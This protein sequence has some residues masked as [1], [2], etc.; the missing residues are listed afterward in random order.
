[1]AKINGVVKDQKGKILEN[2][3]VLFVDRASNVLASG[4]SNKD[5]EY[6]LQISE[7]TNGMVVG[8]YS[9]GEEYLAFAFDNVSTHLPHHIEIIVGDVEFVQFRRIITRDR[10]KYTCSF[11]LAS[12][13]RM[14]R[15]E[16]HL[17]PEGAEASLQFRMD[18]E[19]M[20]AYQLTKEIVSV[21]GRGNTIDFWTLSFAFELK[22]RGKVLELIYKDK[23]SYGILKSY[24]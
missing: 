1:M 13:S 12:L 10:E 15:G 24:V 8:T 9:Y 22:D 19:T 2:A 7:K 4:Y 23:D 6:Y 16:I 18:G 3:E 17:S 11:Q 20:K 21:E 5:G 14:K